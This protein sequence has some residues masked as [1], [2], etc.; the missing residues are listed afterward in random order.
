VKTLVP[1][2]TLMHLKTELIGVKKLSDETIKCNAMASFI[3]SSFLMD[4]LH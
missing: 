2:Q 4:L 3:N 1:S